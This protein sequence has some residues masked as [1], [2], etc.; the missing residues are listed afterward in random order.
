DYARYPV[1]S[2]PWVRGRLRVSALWIGLTLVVLLIPIVTGDQAD[3]P[4]PGFVELALSLV[5]PA[6]VGPWLG[7]RVRRLGLPARR[8]WWALVGAITFVVAAMTVYDRFGSEPLKQ[9]VAERSGTVDAQGK[10]K[11]VMMSIG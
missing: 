4:W 3:K 6:I 10:R 2:A 5:V 1:F 9:W 8:E 7:N 11:R